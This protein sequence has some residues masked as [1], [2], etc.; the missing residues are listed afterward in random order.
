MKEI[1]RTYDDRI[2]IEF[3]IEVTC[4]YCG[5]VDVTDDM[6]IETSKEIYCRECKKTYVVYFSS[7]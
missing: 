3:E 5:D 7:D 2:A 1:F 4:P 6:D